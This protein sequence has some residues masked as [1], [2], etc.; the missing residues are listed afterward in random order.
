MI[1]Q[2]IRSGATGKRRVE[3]ALG[4]L[5]VKETGLYRADHQIVDMLQLSGRYGLR[6][7]NSSVLLF[8][9]I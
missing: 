5:W 9:Q 7:M 6:Q 1:L 8:F 3:N 4:I 2:E